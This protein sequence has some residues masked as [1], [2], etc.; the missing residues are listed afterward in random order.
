MWT[1]ASPFPN[2][3]KFLNC[4]TTFLSRVTSISWGFS[5]PAWQFR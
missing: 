2:A 5:G 4:Q 3:S 1:D